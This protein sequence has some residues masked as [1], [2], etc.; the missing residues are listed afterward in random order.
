MTLVG[1]VQFV[2]NRYGIRNEK[3]LGNAFD[4]TYFFANPRLGLNV[5][6]TEEV[7]TYA[8]VGYTSREPR[9]RNLYAAEDAYFGATPSFQATQMPSPVSTSWWGS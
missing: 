3:F 7:H 2:Y 8:F 4:L 5:N 1:D 6:L 9:M